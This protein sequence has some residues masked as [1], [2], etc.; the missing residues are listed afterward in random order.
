MFQ[1][2]NGEHYRVGDIVRLSK[3]DQNNGTNIKNFVL[4]GD[5]AMRLAYPEHSVQ[6]TAL[7]GNEIGF[8]PDTLS[9]LSEVNIQGVI[10]GFK[11]GYTERF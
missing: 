4:L 2:P 8:Y 3:T 1:R 5:P 10:I 9:A 7:N 6:T 11:W